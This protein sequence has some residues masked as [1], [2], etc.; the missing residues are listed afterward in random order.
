MHEELLVNGISKLRIMGLGKVWTT[1]VVV[2]RKFV[3]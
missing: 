1:E 2:S 3:L